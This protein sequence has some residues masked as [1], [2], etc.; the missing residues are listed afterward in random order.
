MNKELIKKAKMLLKEFETF[1]EGDLKEKIKHQNNLEELIEF[2]L[3]KL[4]VD[5][6]ELIIKMNQYA[7]DYLNAHNFIKNGG[8]KTFESE[9]LTAS[10]GEKM[11]IFSKYQDTFSDE[12][13]W[14][15]LS[16]TYIMQDFMELPYMLYKE[17]F[18]SP[19]ENKE[20]L[21]SDTERKFLEQLPEEITIYRGGGE[22]E[23][24]TGFGISWTLNKTI[25]EQF[26]E[27]KKHSS[28]DVMFVHKLTIPKSKVVAY[29]NSRKEEEIIYIE[30]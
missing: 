22:K 1:N 23:I 27:R 30:N 2:Y 19:R 12:D 24:E 4:E 14:K 13:Y 5:E 18:S 7:N 6:I 9:I 29:F 28:N 26:V 8:K 17:M 21:M 25:A 20:M 3:E 16:E 11:L 10:K 15:N